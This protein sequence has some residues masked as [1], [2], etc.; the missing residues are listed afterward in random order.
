MKIGIHLSSYMGSWDES[1][2]D[3][4]PHAA[5]TGYKAVELPLM[6][7]DQYDC[8][9]TKNL[10]REYEMECTCGTGV[11]PAEDPSS[12]DKE[13]RRKGIERLKKCISIASEL[14]ADCLGGVLYSPWGI[15]KPRGEAAENYKWA[16]ESIAE[17]ADYAKR[18]GVT[19]SLE[20]LN[21]YESYFMNTMEEG[22]DF[23]KKIGKPNVKLHFDTFHAFIE[24]NDIKQAILKGNNQIF[25]VHL[26][27]NN[28]CA[29][30]TGRVDF[31]EIK[32]ALTTIGYDRYLMVEN[33]ILPNTEAGNETCIWRDSKRTVYE[34]AE[35]AFSYVNKLF[36][37]Q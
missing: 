4:I 2:L 14:E 32:D 21:R 1:A 37:E 28:R 10:L 18:N 3:Y 17:T 35:M 11:N 5:H 19:L 6:I 26:C 15:R 34:N 30:G 29:P 13:I 20:I 33:F 16:A 25:H 23:I 27:D 7:P 8:K 9:K 31:K 22:L 12:T 24:E 36:S